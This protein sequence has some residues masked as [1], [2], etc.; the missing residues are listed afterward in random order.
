MTTNESTSRKAA[1]SSMW[2]AVEKA[3]SLGIQFVITMVLARLLSPSDYGV[4]AMLGIFIAVAAQFINCGFGTALIRKDECSQEDF[5]TAFYFNI[6]VSIIIYLILFIAAPYIAKFYEQPLLC[7]VLRVYG[8]SLIIAAIC[9]VQQVM[10]TRKLDF[11]STS[12]ITTVS[13]LLSGVVGV[14]C[15]Y[16]GMGAWALVIQHITKEVLITVCLFVIIRWVPSFT[17]SKKSL[18]YLW[19]F[20]SKMLASGLIS[21]V[22]NQLYN[23]FVGKVYNSATLGLYNRGLQISNI[24]PDIVQSVFVRNSLPLMSQCQNDKERLIHV[25]RE[26][27]KLVSFLTFPMVCLMVI[28]AKPFVLFF[29]TDKWAECIPYVQIFCLGALFIPL[30]VVNY[31]VLLAAGHPGATLKAEIIK[32]TVGVLV[33][34][35]LVPIGPVVLAIGSSLYSVFAYIINLYFAKKYVGISFVEQLLDLVPSFVISV[36]TCIIVWLVIMFIP[37]YLLQLIVGG[38]LELLLYFVIT[39]YI[40]KFT[41]YTQIL[42]LIK[43]NK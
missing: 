32:K 33:I 25:Y 36:I 24:Y 27:C 26:F 21:S 40:F 18:S 38:L 16:K 35:I 11:K 8:I 12:I 30:S 14:F 19:N 15:A 6:G 29:L 43:K 3:S 28:L 20:G 41:I 7:P 22:Y 5:S 23:L 2:A 42:G 31:N 9:I 13:A 1:K 34:I 17:F 10:L 4:I 39:K 37:G